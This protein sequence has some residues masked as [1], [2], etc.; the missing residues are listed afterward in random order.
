LLAVERERERER[1]RRYCEESGGMVSGDEEDSLWRSSS[2]KEV[3]NA[4][5][6]EMRCLYALLSRP[7]RH[8]TLGERDRSRQIR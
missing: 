5:D 4:D 6:K 3:K 7:C 1:W 2:Q 8:E